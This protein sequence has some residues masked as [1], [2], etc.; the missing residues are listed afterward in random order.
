M[1]G[2][3]SLA[4]WANYIDASW[5]MVLHHSPTVGKTRLR[6]V[7]ERKGPVGA[8]KGVHGKTWAGRSQLG[9][10]RSRLGLVQW[11]TRRPARVLGRRAPPGAAHLHWGRF[12]PKR[13]RKGCCGG[14]PRGGPPLAAALAG[15]GT[16]REAHVVGGAGLAGGGPGLAQGGSASRRRGPRGDHRTPPVRLSPKGDVAGFGWPVGWR[17]R[18]AQAARRRLD[19]YWNAADA[20]DPR[21][22]RLQCRWATWPQMVG[23]RA[24]ESGGPGREVINFTYW[25]DWRRRRAGPARRLHWWWRHG[26][27]GWRRRRA[28]KQVASLS[29]A[30]WMPMLTRWLTQTAGAC[31]DAGGVIVVTWPSMIGMRTDAGSGR[32]PRGLRLRCSWWRGQL[33]LALGLSQAAGALCEVGTLILLMT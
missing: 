12:G 21:D 33:W 23:E 4:T 9:R 8:G 28:A 14:G 24:D 1:D 31:C 32:G 3:P 27:V 26:H 18:Q 10:A 2:P 15:G 22:G 13:A 19:F 25:E 30:T 6:R 7:E 17:R 29:L 11:P 20:G 16:G 5:W